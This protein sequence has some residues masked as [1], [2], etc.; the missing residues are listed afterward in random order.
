MVYFAVKVFV[1]RN[2]VEWLG[3]K[4]RRIELL[5]WELAI[6]IKMSN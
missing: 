5:C 2:A 6:L 4:E 3:M 1:R